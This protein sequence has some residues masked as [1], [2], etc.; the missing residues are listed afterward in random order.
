MSKALISAIL[1][2]Y[3]AIA[4]GYAIRYH[5][6]KLRSSGL[7]ATRF[8]SCRDPPCADCNEA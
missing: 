3:F 7:D 6:R 1:L 4:L 5:R 8:L 2:A